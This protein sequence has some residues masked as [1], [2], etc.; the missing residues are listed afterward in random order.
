MKGGMAAHSVVFG[1]IQALEWQLI[2]K[3]QLDV[4]GAEPGLFRTVSDW[5][6]IGFLLS[7]LFATQP[8]S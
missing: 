6:V 2:S 4:V 3:Y 5:Y 1:V 7:L 8:D